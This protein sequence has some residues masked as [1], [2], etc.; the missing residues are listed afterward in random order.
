MPTTTTTTTVQPA[1]DPYSQFKQSLP[2]SYLQPF[3]DI[4][5]NGPGGTPQQGIQYFGP[6]G[7]NP[8]AVTPQM[9]PW[10]DQ[11]QSTA[12]SAI[13]SLT[14]NPFAYTPGQGFAQNPALN[15]GFQGLNNVGNLQ[16][17]AAMGY[18]PSGQASFFS[19]TQGTAAQIGAP[20]M[21]S[22][23]SMSPAQAAAAMAAAANMGG[24]FTGTASQGQAALAGPAAQVDTSFLQN[25]MS[26][27]APAWLQPWM[28]AA[29]VQGMN[30]YISQLASG[31]DSSGAEGA[32]QR[33]LAVMAPGIASQASAAGL[34]RGGAAIEAQANA[35]ANMMVPIETAAMQTREQALA[36]AANLANQNLTFGANAMNQRQL[37][38]AGMLGQAN[39][40]NAGFNQQTG[41]FNAQ[42][43]Q[44][45]NMQNA[46][47]NQQMTMA[48]LA[49]Q[50]A[51]ALANA[52]FQQQANIANA[53]FGQQANLANAGFQ[54]QAGQTNAELAN[55]I[56]LG[57]LS[58]GTQIGLGNLNAQNSM[59]LANLSANTQAGLANM[60][61]AN[62]M[63]RTNLG[64]A[65]Q[66]GL[67][68]LGNQQ[69]ANLQN[70]QGQ[71]GAGMAGA[72]AMLGLGQ[73]GPQFGLQQMNMLPGM[74]N[75]GLNA[76]SIPSQAA[77][78]Q[79]QN[80]QQML[81]SL[82]G[83]GTGPM[84]QT[85]VTQTPTNVAGI[86][87]GGLAGVGSILGAAPGVI[88]WLKTLFG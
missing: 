39:I 4:Q 25:M 81:L 53:G 68:N 46:G 15:A 85:T 48:N 35:G 71:Y 8:W 66:F 88:D 86:V 79:Y 20:P 44:E 77:Q 45:A 72:Q 74:L 14:Q 33:A 41:M 62:D 23:A 7:P 28:S 13:G 5:N 38:A 9:Q 42:S 49:N 59:N 56:A 50:Q 80:Q 21:A 55:Q 6:D 78:K 16:M 63:T 60:N 12:G 73:F 1:Q 40:A 61:S 83:A 18:A 76:A 43:Q 69:Q 11:M 64:L 52:G 27:Q 29:G 54:Q 84:G 26:D 10:L 37:Q 31:G 34:G 17:Q 75:M 70:Y 36:A 22:S 58:A 87:G 65:G 82:L 24:G 3:S 51:A 32:A 19:P 47:F 57:N 2:G 67:A 30:P